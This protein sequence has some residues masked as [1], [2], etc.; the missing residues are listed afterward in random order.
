MLT[1]DKV[2]TAAHC[3]KDPRFPPVKD[4][5]LIFGQS[6]LEHLANRYE[7]RIKNHKIPDGYEYPY[8]LKD[9]AILQLDKPVK[10][11]M[12][13]FPV[14]LPRQPTYQENRVGISTFVVGYGKIRSTPSILKLVQLNILSDQESERILVIFKIVYSNMLKVNEFL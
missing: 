11:T 2:L 14:C 3:L 6:N 5:I 7:R 12:K 10:V 1:E 13:T 4:I 9:V 8:A